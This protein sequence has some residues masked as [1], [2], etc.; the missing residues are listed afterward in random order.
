MIGFYRIIIRSL[1][2]YLLLIDCLFGTHLFGK[3][4]SAEHGQISA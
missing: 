1:L 3:N 4:R 2:A